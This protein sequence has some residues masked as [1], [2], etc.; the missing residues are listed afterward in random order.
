[1]K[2]TSKSLTGIAALISVAVAA[3]LLYRISSP[4]SSGDDSHVDTA[5]ITAPVRFPDVAPNPSSEPEDAPPSELP[6]LLTAGSFEDAVA[7][8]DRSLTQLDAQDVERGRATILAW[9]AELIKQ[10]NVARAEELLRIYTDLFFQDIEAMLLMADALA[11]QGLLAESLD[12][13]LQ[14]RN[15]AYTEEQ[16]ISLDRKLIVSARTCSEEL[17]SYD[18][19]HGVVSI[20]QML[21]NQYPNNGEFSMELARAVAAVGRPREAYALLQQLRLNPGY[22]QRAEDYLKILQPELEKFYADGTDEK[23]PIEIPLVPQGR[24]YSIS[25]NVDGADVSLLLDTGASITTLKPEIIRR[26]SATGSNRTIT[27]QTANGP[28]QSRLYR[29]RRF[30]LGS[31]ELHNFE[32]ASIPLTGLDGIDG[33]L[34]TDFLR[35]FHYTIN[36]RTNTLVL[37]PLQLDP[38]TENGPG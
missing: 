16:V 10:E 38:D 8:Y 18:D 37:A 4:N 17:R 22:Q 34:G 6:A 31:V 25:A 11:A 13:L 14:A 3:L 28:T 9:A 7:N 32:L 20:Y 29:V 24:H 35:L 15:M 21:Y 5:V 12:Y 36:N 27:L 26:I 23:L 19:G 1:M 2:F 33:L 30:S